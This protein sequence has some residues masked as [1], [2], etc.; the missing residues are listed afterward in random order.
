VPQ[1]IGIS[2]LPTVRDG[3]KHDDASCVGGKW[4]KSGAKIFETQADARE[5]REKWAKWR[6]FTHLCGTSGKLIEEARRSALG[7]DGRSLGH[8]KRGPHSHQVTGLGGR[9]LTILAAMARATTATFTECASPLR[10]RAIPQEGLMAI[11]Q[12]QAEQD[13]GQRRQADIPL[14]T[15][16]SFYDAAI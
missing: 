8:I 5:S 14:L 10:E 11:G 16:E 1:R 13:T 4:A 7:G 15:R 9:H 2:R 12:R 3:E 6:P